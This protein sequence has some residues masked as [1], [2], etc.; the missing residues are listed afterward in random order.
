MSAKII[1]FIPN[2]RKKSRGLVALERAVITAEEAKEF[3]DILFGGDS[4]DEQPQKPE[5]V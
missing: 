1:Q 2:P 3:N 5:G 4:G